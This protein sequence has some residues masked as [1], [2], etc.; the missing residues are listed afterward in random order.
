M[1]ARK[2]MLDAVA[3]AV[4]GVSGLTEWPHGF[5]PEGMSAAVAID[6]SSAGS[7][8][9]EMASTTP[10]ADRHRDRIHLSESIAVGLLVDVRQSDH[11][12]SLGI[13]LDL[14]DLI[15]GA[16]LSSIAGWSIV[17][18]GIDRE[19]MGADGGGAPFI[20][21]RLSFDA[22]ATVAF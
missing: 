22:S 11:R 5:D 7:F 20:A 12:A 8:S 2:T 21:V 4:E 13:A 17:L 16:L 1:G 14:E 18:T 10:L 6:A 15:V 9:V 19:P 3:A